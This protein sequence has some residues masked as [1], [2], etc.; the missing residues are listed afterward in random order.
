M[1]LKIYNFPIIIKDPNFLS[2]GINSTQK[3][4]LGTCK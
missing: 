4:W 2:S 1:I 3:H